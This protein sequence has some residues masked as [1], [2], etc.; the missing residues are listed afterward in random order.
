MNTKKANKK[1]VGED[2]AT[3]ETSQSLSSCSRHSSHS[4]LLSLSVED[5]EESNDEVETLNE[6]DSSSD[7]ESVEEEPDD[8]VPETLNMDGELD[9]FLTKRNYP[10]LTSV[11]QRIA[12]AY[13]FHNVFGS[14][15]DSD[16]T[17][18]LGRDNIIPKIRTQ[19]NISKHTNLYC[20]LEDII[21]YKQQGTAYLGQRHKGILP[22]G[23]QS[24]ISLD[25]VEAQVIA[26]CL[27]SGF[28]IPQTQW[29]VNQHRKESGEPSFTLSPIRNCI[30]RLQPSIRK[31]LR[32]SQGSDDP[33]SPWARARCN[34]IGQLLIRFGLNRSK[35]DGKGN[36]PDWLNA[37]KMPRLEKCQ[38]AWWDEIMHSKCVI[39]GLA[40]GNSSS[41]VRF[42][43]DENGKLDLTNGHYGNQEIVQVHVKFEKEVHLCFG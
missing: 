43:R 36:I 32:G 26:D 13:V 24:F 29:Q 16:D 17:P 4:S 5:E 20:V 38:A 31:V 28:S 14:P 10:L 41:Y 42:K 33:N 25:S 12:V 15:E 9:A 8:E 1:T 7:D 2:D 37:E 18:W 3:A 40:A 11:A 27:E 19:L 21:A 30:K 22:L 23:R 39:G 35:R 6:V 34:W